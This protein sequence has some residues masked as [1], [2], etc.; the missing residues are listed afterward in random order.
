MQSKTYV[1]FIFV[2]KGLFVFLKSL[3]NVGV[4]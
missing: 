2:L 4:K 3:V 1:T